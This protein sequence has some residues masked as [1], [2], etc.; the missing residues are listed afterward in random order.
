MH[1]ATRATAARQEA[2]AAALLTELPADIAAYVLFHLDVLSLARLACTA[3]KVQPLVE[4]ALRMRAAEASAWTPASLPSGEV[5]F[6]PLLLRSDRRRSLP[7]QL[8]SAGSWH[9]LFVDAEGQIYS[10]GVER[11]AGPDRRGLLGHGVLSDLAVGI[12][13]PSPILALA[14]VKIRSVCARAPW[15]PCLSAR[16][17]TDRPCA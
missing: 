17:P 3:R 9:S 16:T 5:S 8:I 10:C 1:R 14:G 11:S 6:L 15:V 12:P 4:A 13:L 2:H 7:Q